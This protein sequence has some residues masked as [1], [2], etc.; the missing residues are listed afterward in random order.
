[1]TH[2]TPD[3]FLTRYADLIV[4]VGLNL[5]PGQRLLISAGGTVGDVAP[6]VRAVAA[7][8]Y[9][10]GARFVDILWGDEH[11]TLARLQH[12]DPETLT[13]YPDW[14][15]ALLTDYAEK[16]D[17]IL[18]ITA[19]NPDYLDG[20]N[21]EHVALLR[22]VAGQHNAPYR[23]AMAHNHSNWC[24]VG[25]AAPGWAAKVFPDVAGSEAQL[26]RLWDAIFAM[27]RLDQPDP[28]AAWQAHIGRIRARVDY[29][30]A[31][32][33]DAVRLTGPGTDLTVGLVPGHLWEGAQSATTGGV[34]FTPNLPTEEMFTIPH[35]LRVDGTVRASLPLSLSGTLIDDFALRFEAGRVVDVTARK[36]EHALRRLVETDDGAARLGELALV[37]AS[38][39]I[40]QTGRLFYNTL[41]DENAACHIALGQ[42]YRINLPDGATLSEEAFAA[43]G[44]NNSLVHV[45]FMIGSAAVDVDGIRADGSAEPLMRA[46]EWAFSV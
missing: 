38:S 8:A 45:D 3:H 21:P 37:P 11:V 12:A 17:A 4:R 23:R 30:T 25:A 7:V 15:V 35:R 42:A 22:R 1:M 20:Q 31:R 9:G 14:Q 40:A 13:N 5:Q 29:L 6:L 19:A 10:A 33:Y 16:G 43:V 34:R 46:G 18:S 41:Y 36:G 2:T 26:A 44:G 24:V 28:V 32:Q 27:C 39:P